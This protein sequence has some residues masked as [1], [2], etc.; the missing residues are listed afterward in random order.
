MFLRRIMSFARKGRSM[1]VALFIVAEQD[2]VGLDISVCGK[3]LAHCRP[4]GGK[5]RFGRSAGLHLEMLA[6]EAGVMPLMEFF[7]LAPEEARSL[8]GDC[9][10]EEPPGGLPPERWF[11]ASEGLATVRG[12]LAHLVVNPEAAA[13][14][15]RLV[16]DLRQF[17]A[18]LVGLD[19]AGVGWHLSVDY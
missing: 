18:V 15:D 13:E 9:G 10:G 6:K 19:E 17:E 2:V 12:L 1:S 8:L 5:G 16:E 4:A 11:P 7:S 3:S 14:V